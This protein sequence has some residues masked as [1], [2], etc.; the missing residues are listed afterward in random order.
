MCHGPGQNYHYGGTGQLLGRDLKR[1]RTWAH[2]PRQVSSSQTEWRPRSREVVGAQYFGCWPRLYGQ[3]DWVKA[4]DRNEQGAPRRRSWEPAR[5]N[6]KKLNQISTNS[7]HSPF[8][9]SCCHALL[10]QHLGR[11]C[12]PT[13]AGWKSHPQGQVHPRNESRTSVTVKSKRPGLS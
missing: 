1:W 2:E 6:N 8:H 4:E 11:K 12:G 9:F 7:A 3:T 10:F 13:T 5:R